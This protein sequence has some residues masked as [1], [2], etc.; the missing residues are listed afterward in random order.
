MTEFGPQQQQQEL[1]ARNPR[2]RLSA[3]LSPLAVPRR[4]RV[5]FDVN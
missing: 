1:A 4:M 5:H 3:P 2:R